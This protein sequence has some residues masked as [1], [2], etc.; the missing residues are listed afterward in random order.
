MQYFKSYGLLKS[1]G[2]NYV[3]AVKNAWGWELLPTRT[4]GAERVNGNVCPKF[5]HCFVWL[6]LKSVPFLTSCVFWFV[7]LNANSHLCFGFLLSPAVFLCNN[8]QEQNRLTKPCARKITKLVNNHVEFQNSISGVGGWDWEVLWGFVILVSFLVSLLVSLPV[9]SK[10][11]QGCETPNISHSTRGRRCI[12]KYWT[13]TVK[14]MTEHCVSNSMH[15]KQK[16]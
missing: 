13:T 12:N 3:S 10:E 2:E 8:D 6:I 1:S 14:M 4:A 7:F 16:S 5:A 9:L 15:A 11:W